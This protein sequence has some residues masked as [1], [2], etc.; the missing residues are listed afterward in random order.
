MLIKEFN[1]SII[2]VRVYG[3][4]PENADSC[5]NKPIFSVNVSDYN[6]IQMFYDTFSEVDDAIEQFNKY[7][8][9][10]EY[11]DET[12]FG[13]DRYRL[14]VDNVQEAVDATFS[15]FFGEDLNK[16]TLCNFIYKA[17]SKATQTA[18]DKAFNK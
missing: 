17:I 7:V 6:C 15:K 8:Q 5:D 9:L 4:V 11:V 13:N 2:H 1:S 12:S 3:I 10:I 16:T 14:A 18:I